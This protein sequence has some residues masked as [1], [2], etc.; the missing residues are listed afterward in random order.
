MS[1]LAGEAEAGPRLDLSAI[2]CV[3]RVA[4]CRGL[5]RACAVATGP[6]GVAGT[7]PCAGEA[8]AGELSACVTHK[9]FHTPKYSLFAK[10]FFPLD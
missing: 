3:A 1:K 5:P 8:R 2:G 4:A 10:K 7:G 6:G 9:S